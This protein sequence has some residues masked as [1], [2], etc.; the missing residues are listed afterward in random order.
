MKNKRADTRAYVAKLM[1]DDGVGISKFIA[2]FIQGLIVLSLMI[3][4][5]DTLPDKSEGLSRLLDTCEFVIVGLFTLEYGLRLWCTEKR[6]KYIFSFYAA[7]DLVA[8]LPY[9]FVGAGSSTQVIRIVRMLRLLRILKLA[10][11]SKA[12]DRFIKAFH[13]IREELVLFAAVSALMLFL[14]SAGIY[15]FENEAQPKVFASVF[16]SMWWAVATMT[17]VGYGD[18]YPITA[19]G[20]IFTFF[21]LMTGLGIVAV[22][23]GLIATALTRV[24][25]KEDKEDLKELKKL[26]ELEEQA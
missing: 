10:R 18:I 19:G 15:H 9:Y 22:P 24:K 6:L 2:F 3:Y 7:I 11:Y 20:K 14:A 4:A 1:N 23:T 16:H 26:K 13:M 21:V 5:V 8:I 12:A 25:A 17:T